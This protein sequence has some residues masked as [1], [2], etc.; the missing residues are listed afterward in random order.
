MMDENGPLGDTAKSESE[1]RAFRDPCEIGP[2]GTIVVRGAEADGEKPPEVCARQLPPKPPERQR[3]CRDCAAFCSF[4]NNSF[5][6]C[7]YDPPT[8]RHDASGRGLD[9]AWPRVNLGGWCRK[10]E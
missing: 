5:G 3:I 2:F 6:E 4:V 8:L 1:P 9:G 7:R 10:W